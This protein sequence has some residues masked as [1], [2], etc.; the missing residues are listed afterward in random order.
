MLNADIMNIIGIIVSPQADGDTS[1]LVNEVLKG[2]PRPGIQP[3]STAS[4]K[5]G[6]LAVRP[7]YI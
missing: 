5:W 2:L 7:A 1:T 3:K 4:M 6:P